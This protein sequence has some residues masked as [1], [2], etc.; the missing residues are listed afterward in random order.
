MYSKLQKREETKN[1]NPSSL[2]LSTPLAN[3]NI[4]ALQQT[5][6]NRA[7]AQ[8]MKSNFAATT[9]QR[10][11]SGVPTMPGLSGGDRGE[12]RKRDDDEKDERKEEAPPEKKVR[13][14]KVGEWTKTLAG[15]RADM[16]MSEGDKFC[17]SFYRDD[18]DYHIK[19][20][21]GV[22]TAYQEGLFNGVYS[23]RVTNGLVG[24]KNKTVRNANL[25]MC[26]AAYT[27]CVNN[28][29]PLYND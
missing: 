8:M 19:G 24:K 10:S 9:V 20:K 4:A 21:K 5:I 11:T 27:F 12:K 15:D 13:P 16:W 28:I 2:N 25:E 17:F 3:S 18:H 14:E 7:V 29:V 26:R 1:T 23:L 6:G 22:L